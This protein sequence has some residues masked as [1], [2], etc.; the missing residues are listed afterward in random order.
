MV[1][2]ISLSE[3]QFCEDCNEITAKTPHGKCPICQSHATLLLHNILNRNTQ[4]RV[5]DREKIQD[6][7]FPSYV[8]IRELLKIPSEG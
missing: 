4:V 6:M 2:S 3:A 8:R 5:R 1:T 7:M